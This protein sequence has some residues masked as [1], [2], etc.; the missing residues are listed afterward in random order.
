MIILYGS[1]EKYIDVTNLCYENSLKNNMVLEIP[2]GDV[3]RCILFNNQ[4]PH[5]GVLKKIFIIR[6]NRNKLEIDHTYKIIVNFLDESITK[7]NSLDGS[8][9]KIT[10]LKDGENLIDDV[11]KKLKEIHSKLVLNYG[12]FNDEYEEQ[13]MAISY[14]KGDEKILEIGGN[15]G[16]NTLV[17]NHILGN[18]E[19]HLV[20]LESNPDIA[21]QLCENRDAN[22]M[23]FHVEASALSKR[24]LIQCHWNTMVSD[25]V[26]PGYIEIKTITVDELR[27]K[28]NIAF[29]TLV[30]DC[31][32]AFYYILMDM[33]E[34]LDGIKLIIMENDY[35][36]YE[37]KI[38]IDNILTQ[39]GFRVDY[40]KKGGWGPCYDFFF[41][42]W[43]RD[44][45]IN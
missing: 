30:L 32:G 40:K 36:E 8:M 4:D 42:V 24:K 5:F 43:K 9:I 18:K 35:F 10:N 44:Q 13:K 39:K 19:N 28:Y 2:S 17:I 37:K 6:S 22:K 34:I 29:D 7:I 31:E 16:R 45:F 25:V 33:P 26:L 20:S 1:N 41:E 15:V 38:F 21:I 12:T 11:D 27:S 3:E 23:N 14:L